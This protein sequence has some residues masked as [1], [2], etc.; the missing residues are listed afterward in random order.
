[1]RYKTPSTTAAIAREMSD[2]DITPIANGR[3]SR[4]HSGQLTIGKRIARTAA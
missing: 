2:P 3:N 4:R 1:M